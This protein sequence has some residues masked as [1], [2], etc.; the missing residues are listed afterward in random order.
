MRLAAEAQARQLVVFTH[1]LVFFN[2]LCREAETIHVQVSAVALFANK[3]DA[4][5]IDLGGVTWKG[6]PVKKRVAEIKKEF[7][8]V[9]A[10]HGDS[11]SDYEFKVKG[12]YGRLRDTYERVVGE[13]IF[14]QVVTRGADRIETLRLRCVHLSDELAVRF[15]EGMTKANTFSHDNPA[16][17]TVKT[18]DPAEFEADLAHLEQLIADLDAEGKAAEAR[19][20]V[21]KPKK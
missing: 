2:D 17:E 3:V 15:H 20:L 11:D 4:G 16:A 19:R 1:D 8:A 18:P 13:C 14:N 21:M 7:P 5:K 6:L 10:R 9:Q 12:L